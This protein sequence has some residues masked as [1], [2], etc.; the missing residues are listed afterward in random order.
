MGARFISDLIAKS[1]TQDELKR[2][3][4]AD[5]CMA[6]VQK[7]NVKMMPK[8]ICS[9][10]GDKQ[11]TQVVNIDHCCSNNRRWILGV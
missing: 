7:F 5:I 9:L 8:Y 11:W 3:Y 10:V 1:M 6:M 4:G 2:R